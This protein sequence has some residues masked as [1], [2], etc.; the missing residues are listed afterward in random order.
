MDI[1]NFNHTLQKYLFLF[2]HST[3]GFVSKLIKSK[4]YAS[5]L[6]FLHLSANSFIRFFQLNFKEND[7]PLCE[8]LV[9]NINELIAI[10]KLSKL[11]LDLHCRCPRKNWKHSAELLTILYCLTLFLSAL[12]CFYLTFNFEC[13][14]HVSLLRVLSC[15]ACNTYASF[16]DF[17]FLK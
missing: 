17:C 7:C 8:R 15:W 12:L 1:E 10:S 4:I 5:F 11:Y 13:F 9:G 6:I 3:V 2:S 16:Y 14:S